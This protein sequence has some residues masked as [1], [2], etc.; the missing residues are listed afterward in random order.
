MKSIFESVFIKILRK[1]YM[2]YLLRKG[3]MR[4]P[5]TDYIEIKNQKLAYL[6]SH[7]RSVMEK[8]NT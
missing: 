7:I 3:K 2:I 8:P 4:M 5:K 1:R 6:L